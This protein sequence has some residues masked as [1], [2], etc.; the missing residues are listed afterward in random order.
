MYIC[1]V[2][3]LVHMQRNYKSASKES[4][5]TSSKELSDGHLS[6][7]AFLFPIMKTKYIPENSNYYVTSEGDVYSKNYQG[8]KGRKHKM[9]PALSKKGYLY[10]HLHE[11][12]KHKTMVIH[13]LVA[14]AFI[15]NPCNLPQ[16]SHEDSA[17]ASIIFRRTWKHL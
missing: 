5:F 3:N 13:R 10:V 12:G 15:P 8:V 16:V 11:K 4:L 1:C 17:I 7:E 9:R 14:M 2:Q 6:A